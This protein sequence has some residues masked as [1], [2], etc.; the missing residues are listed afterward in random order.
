LDTPE[1]KSEVLLSEYISEESD[2]AV[3]IKRDQPVMLVIGN[4]PYSYESENTGEWITSLVR[5]YYHV[6]GKPLGERN[7]KGLQDDYVKFIRFAQWKIEK[8]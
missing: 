7:P 8:T 2:R 3:A 1:R 6:D 4:P 5:D